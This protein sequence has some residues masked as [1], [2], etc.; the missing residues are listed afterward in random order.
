MGY[1][2]E[3]MGLPSPKQMLETIDLYSGFIGANHF[4]ILDTLLYHLI[5]RS[6]FLRK[7]TEQAMD[8]TFT[9]RNAQE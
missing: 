2:G 1:I 4:T 3:F 7:P 9:N 5:Y 6:G 8:P